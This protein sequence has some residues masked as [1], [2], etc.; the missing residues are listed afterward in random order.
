MK[1]GIEAVADQPAESVPCI[2]EESAALGDGVNLHDDLHAIGQHEGEGE[3]ETLPVAVDGQLLRP[4]GR[5]RVP[6][7]FGVEGESGDGIVY[8]KVS[9]NSI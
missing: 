5:E 6:A 8:H 3:D 9:P 7:L 1:S 2:G 4:K